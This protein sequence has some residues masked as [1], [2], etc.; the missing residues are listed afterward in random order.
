MRQV[1]PSALL[2]GLSQ[3][4]INMTFDKQHSTT[5]GL[6]PV[7]DAPSICAG[8]EVELP[9]N[10]QATALAHETQVKCYLSDLM[11]TTGHDLRQPLQV[12]GSILELLELSSGVSS[13]PP[14]FKRAH[15]AIAR[16]A[17]GLDRL[18]FASSL[19]PRSDAPDISTFPI[20]QV[21][22]LLG[23]MWR[24][25]AVQKGIRLRIVASSAFVTSDLAM[26]T[27]ILGNLVGNAIK[28]TPRGS[29]LVGCRRH[30]DRLSIQVAD[31]GIGISGERLNAIFAPFHQE[32]PQSAGLGL[33]LAIVRRS[34]DS[35]GHRIR[36]KSVVGRGSIFSVVVPLKSR[37]HRTDTCDL[38]LS[39]Q[40]YCER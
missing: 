36:V 23:S 11:A 40:S 5:S 21:L 26:L 25:P 20:A 27:S 10:D 35:L 17:A 19:A 24:Y 34:A 32:D 4:Q 30:G 37:S 29:V 28:Y 18:A 9:S 22:H 15:E 14:Q 3:A 39:R 2:T 33:G 1:G 31:S 8:F 16:L 7:V 6:L 12:I 38:A 13:T